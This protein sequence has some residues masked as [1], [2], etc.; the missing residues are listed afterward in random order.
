MTP[1][2][3]PTKTRKS[4]HQIFKLVVLLSVSKLFRRKPPMWTSGFKNSISEHEQSTIPRRGLQL[5]LRPCPKA[6]S[7]PAHWYIRGSPKSDLNTL[8]Q[9]HYFP[10]VK[11]SI[12]F[13]SLLVHGEGGNGHSSGIWAVLGTV[14][15]VLTRPIILSSSRGSFSKKI[16]PRRTFRSDFRFKI[17]SFL[18]NG[19]QLLFC[20]YI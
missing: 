12:F 2:N 14:Q 11:I 20:C 15:N 1:E 17:F 4:N 18:K 19:R 13:K 9:V 3:T 6:Y 7:F 10:L 16:C 5:G 8:Y